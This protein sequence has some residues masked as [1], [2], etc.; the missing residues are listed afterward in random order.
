M[1]EGSKGMINTQWPRKCL[2]PNSFRVSAR[3][4]NLVHGSNQFQIM[5]EGKIEVGDSLGLNSLVGVHQKH[6]PCIASQITKLSG[7]LI[8]LTLASSE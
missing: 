1:L 8:I 4:V 3:E 6:H 5:S 7:I 2:L